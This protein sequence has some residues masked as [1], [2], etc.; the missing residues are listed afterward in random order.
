M[1][2]MQTEYAAVAMVDDLK[3]SA[4]SGSELRLK[5]IYLYNIVI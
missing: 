2:L 4:S 3:A 1:Q 5:Y